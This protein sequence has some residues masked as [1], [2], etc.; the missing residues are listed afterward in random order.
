MTLPEQYTLRIEQ[1]ATLKRWFALQYPDGTIANLATAGTGYTSGTLKI[2]PT[3]ADEP[4]LILTTD[5]GG[6]NLTYQADAN[7]RY[8]SGYIFCAASATAELAPWGDGV[9]DLEVSDGF[10]VVRILQGRAWLS[11]E[12]SY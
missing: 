3:Y 5:N 6:V 7:G 9:F 1:G 2:R 11:H 10:D 8:W 4:V 12:A